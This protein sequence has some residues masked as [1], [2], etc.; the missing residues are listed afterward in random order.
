[1]SARINQ[2]NGIITAIA[3]QIQAIDGFRIQVGSIVRRNESAP[4]GGVVPG[5]TVV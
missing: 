1:M 3:I 4:L 2:V 5:V